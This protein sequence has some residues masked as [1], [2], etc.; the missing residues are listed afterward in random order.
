MEL[1]K[2]K[3][4]R[5]FVNVG[6]VVV[7]SALL[8]MIITQIVKIILVKRG[9]IKTGMNASKKDMVLSW[10]GRTTALVVYSTLY[11]CSEFY[12]HHNV[13]LDVALI[14]GLFSGAT[15]T[16]IVAKAFYTM[17]HQY[18]QKKIDFDKLEDAEKTILALKTEIVDK[19]VNTECAK[20]VKEIIEEKKVI[21]EPKRKWI[22]RGKGE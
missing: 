4:Y 3:D 16:L 9:V 10:V 1:T 21:S 19:Q 14:A 6:F 7:L 22:I 2:I 13:E 17:L 15:L 20:Q 8:T 18:F 5:F 11:I 12:L